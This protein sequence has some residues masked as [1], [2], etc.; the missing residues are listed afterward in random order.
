MNL[1]AAIHLGLSVLDIGIN[2]AAGVAASA[3]G[4]HVN[5]SITT[6]R[7]LR[8]GAL[9]GVI[10]SGILNAA[11]LVSMMAKNFILKALL[12][13]VATTFGMAVLITFA[14]SQEALNQSKFVSENI[15]N[16]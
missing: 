6:I 10:K 2:S 9:G 12:V 14:L 13:F 3:T 15:F 7:I 16:G 1:L 4:A 8:W 5:G 11:I